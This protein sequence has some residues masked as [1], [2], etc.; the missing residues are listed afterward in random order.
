MLSPYKYI[1]H[2]M[3]KVQKFVDYIFYDVWM[4]A[5]LSKRYLTL[6]VKEPFK[7][8]MNDLNVSDSLTSSKFCMLVD[9]IYRIIGSFDRDK[10]DQLKSYYKINSNIEVLCKDITIIPIS[11][12]KLEAEFGKKLKNKIKEFNDLLYGSGSILALKELLKISS[13]GEHYEEFIE[14]NKNRCL[15]CGLDKLEIVDEYR[16]DY[17]H[18]LQ[19][20]Q[21][22][23]VSINLR[24]LAP[25]CDRCNKKFK[26]SKDPLYK[27]DKITRRKA[28]YPYS[29]EKYGFNIDIKLVDIV[30]TKGKIKDKNIDM[31][32][33]VKSDEETK[34]WN[35]LYK[36]EKRY[37]GVCSSKDE[38]DRWIQ[39]AR[40]YMKESNTSL[41]EYI[42]FQKKRLEE[43]DPYFETLFLNIP[44]L[45]AC[46]EADII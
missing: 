18:F 40:L 31:K 5:D 14:E 29:L 21:Y 32:L 11:Y 46:K 3:E 34:T 7:K 45:E 24:N 28:I 16:S 33:L 35:E 17:D 41:D 44:F 26:G 25:T 8:L 23:F 15:F 37:K 36:I 4:E 38:A 22:P 13:F 2:D 30:D 20:A 1:E 10:R 19:K 42:E 27:E 43:I 12:I 9:D 6:F 39:S